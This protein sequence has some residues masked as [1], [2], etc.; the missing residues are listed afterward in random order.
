VSR[1]VA[2]ISLVCAALCGLALAVEAPS[3]E[4]RYGYTIFVVNADGTGRRNLTAGTAAPL[5]L[6]A[7]SPDGRTLAYQRRRVEGGSDLWSIE[8]MPARGGAARTLV[9]LPGKSAYAPAWS[10]DGKLVAFE[11]CCSPDGIGVVRPDGTRFSMIPDASEPAWLPGKRLAFLA[12][13]D[14]RTEIATANPDGSERRSVLGA[15]PFEEFGKLAGSPNGGTLAFTSYREEGAWLHLVGLTGI[16]L[17]QIAEDASDYSWSPTGRRL[18]F[19]T[20]GGLMT[21]HSDGSKVRP[22][23]ATRILSPV[24]PAWSPDATRIAFVAN[25]YRLVVM[26]VRRR[27]LRTI[28]RGVLGQQPLW[29]RDGRRLYYVVARGA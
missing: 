21:V 5:V 6:R 9:S 19:V 23:R 13:G 3:R 29:S 10:R 20:R 26:N 12:G 4:S 17:S 1:R 22:Y 7:L 15:R 24:A 2:V 8:V 27:T 14:L 18:A 16:P 11:M 28:A 25:S